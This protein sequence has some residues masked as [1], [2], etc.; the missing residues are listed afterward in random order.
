MRSDFNLP[1]GCTARDIETNGAPVVSSRSG[2]YSQPFGPSQLKIMKH[3]LKMYRQS[4][5]RQRKI[6]NED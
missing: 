2:R 4:Q 5:D 6:A 3:F 1:L